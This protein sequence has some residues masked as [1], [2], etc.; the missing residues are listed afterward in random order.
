MVL[1]SFTALFNFVILTSSSTSFAIP[2]FDNCV[3]HSYLQYIP[4]CL[5]HLILFHPSI[6]A[7]HLFSLFIHAVY[8]CSASSS[9]LLLRGIPDY[10]SIDTVSELTRRNAT[11]NGE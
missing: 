9:P 11:G 1:Q 10:I 5:G 4:P 2:P 6:L 8:F 3:C 7:F